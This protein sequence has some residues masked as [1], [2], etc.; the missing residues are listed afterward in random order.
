VPKLRVT[1]TLD[2]SLVEAA[3]ASVLQG[4]SES[5]SALVGEALGAQLEND[6]RLLALRDA[7]TTYETAHGEITPE[8]TADLEHRDR[9]AMQ[10][11]GAGKRRAG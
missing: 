3:K 5:V 2:E 9:L 7:L 6:A 1:V 10:V 4:R 8:E 11:A